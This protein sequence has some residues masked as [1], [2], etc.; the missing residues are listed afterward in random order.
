MRHS[1]RL[2]IL[3]VST[4]MQEHEKLIYNNPF[5]ALKN[6]H[7]ALL[8]LRTLGGTNP[9]AELK[10]NTD[11]EL[12]KIYNNMTGTIDMPRPYD[13]PTHVSQLAFF[14][15][16]LFSQSRINGNVS[17]RML[18][19]YIMDG[20]DRVCSILIVSNVGQQD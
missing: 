17:L 8:H 6:Y 12:V 4:G 1:K 19:R 5:P 16:Q 14:F 18:P 11:E 7:H 20:V 2:T 9:P 3:K 10:K 15:I 13:F